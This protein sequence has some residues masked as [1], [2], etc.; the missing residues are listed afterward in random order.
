MSSKCGNLVEHRTTSFLPSATFYDLADAIWFKIVTVNV[1]LISRNDRKWKIE[2]FG[3]KQR[4]S[5]CLMSRRSDGADVT[6]ENQRSLTSLK[7]IRVCLFCDSMELRELSYS[8]WIK[9]VEEIS[10]FATW[11]RKIKFQWENRF[12]EYLKIFAKLE[13]QRESTSSST[14]KTPFYVCDKP[15]KSPATLVASKKHE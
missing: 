13:N 7:I 12:G 4:L 14:S 11:K 2:T 6:K 5:M 10:L 15:A 3:E 8:G 1:K 9:S